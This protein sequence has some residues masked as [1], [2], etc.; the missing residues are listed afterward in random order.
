MRLIFATCTL[1]P[2]AAAEKWGVN[3][4]NQSARRQRRPPQP[5]FSIN[6]ASLAFSTPSTDFMSKPQLPWSDAIPRIRKDARAILSVMPDGEHGLVIERW[7]DSGGPATAP[8]SSKSALYS[9][10]NYWNSGKIIV[11]ISP[12]CCGPP[13]S[14]CAHKP[15]PAL[16][17][18]TQH[19][20]SVRQANH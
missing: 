14:P 4:A 3:L 19:A 5:R 7:Q 17:H 13:W 18:H 9:G 20:H 1:P 12:K 16:L 2:V 11:L 6:S 8:S 15:R 10:R